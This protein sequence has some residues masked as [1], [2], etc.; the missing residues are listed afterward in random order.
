VIVVGS[1]VPAVAFNM[2]GQSSLFWFGESDS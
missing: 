2:T 1:I